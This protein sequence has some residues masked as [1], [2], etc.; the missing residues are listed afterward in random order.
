MSLR[1]KK[2]FLFNLGNAYFLV[3]NYSDAKARYSECIES[4]PN[5]QLKVKAYNNLAL[6][7][8]W[9]KNPLVSS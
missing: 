4:D 6:A 8:W 5:T 9:H 1:H 7:C 2:Q 3:G